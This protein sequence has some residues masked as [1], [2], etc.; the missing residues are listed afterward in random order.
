MNRRRHGGRAARSG[1]AALIGRLH[2]AVVRDAPDGLAVRFDRADLGA[3]SGKRV[4]R[5]IMRR[6]ARE[7]AHDSK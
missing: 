1:A 5:L 2:A 7:P 6:D 3:S 4:H